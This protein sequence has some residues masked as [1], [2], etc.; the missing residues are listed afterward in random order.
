M[1]DILLHRPHIYLVNILSRP[2]WNKQRLW[3]SN[4]LM[5]TLLIILGFHLQD[6]LI[7]TPVVILCWLSSLSLCCPE[8]RRIETRTSLAG[9]KE[10]TYTTTVTI[11]TTHSGF[12]R[13]NLDSIQAASLRDYTATHTSPIINESDYFF[14]SVFFFFTGSTC[15]VCDRPSCLIVSSNVKSCSIIRITSR[16]VLVVSGIKEF[17]SGEVWGSAA[18]RPQQYESIVTFPSFL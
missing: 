17:N 7:I 15:P 4:V 8:A 13:L 18:S 3:Q 12:K 9:V 1:F 14:L 16:V 2:L 10:H 6:P 5:N 11:S